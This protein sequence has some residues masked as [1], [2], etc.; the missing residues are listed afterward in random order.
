MRTFSQA[1]TIRKRGKQKAP[2]ATR[3]KR[4]WTHMKCDI[5]ARESEGKKVEK[6]NKNEET[7]AIAW[8]VLRRSDKCPTGS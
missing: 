2:I 4:G 1:T 7:K 5:G 6:K 3:E 8:C